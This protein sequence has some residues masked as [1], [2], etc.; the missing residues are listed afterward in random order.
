MI[1]ARTPQETIAATKKFIRNSRMDF[2]HRTIIN[3]EVLPLIRAMDMKSLAQRMGVHLSEHTQWVYRRG[4]SPY[5][6]KGKTGRL[7]GQFG[8]WPT[9]YIHY[10][11]D[12][13]TRG[14][15][16][17]RAKSLAILTAQGILL[18]EIGARVFGVDIKKWV[19]WHPMLWRGSPVI[20]ALLDLRGMATGSEYEKAKGWAG[21]KSVAKIHIPYYLAQRGLYQAFEEDKEEDAIKRGLGFTPEKD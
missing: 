17:N 5:W 3:D 2:F 18:E 8:T 7:A 12:L 16:Y 15:K 10:V 4:N 13:A 21:I 9:W 1:A 14:S 19:L 20:S 6:M 11:K